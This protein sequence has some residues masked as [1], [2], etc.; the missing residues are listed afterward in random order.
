MATLPAYLLAKTHAAYGRRL[1]KD[2]YDIAYVVLHNDAGGPTAAAARVQEVLLLTWLA[3]R[4]L[5]SRSW[6]RTSPTQ[7]LREAWHTP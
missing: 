7:M 4:R 6:Q 2:W 1:E 3:R 5:R